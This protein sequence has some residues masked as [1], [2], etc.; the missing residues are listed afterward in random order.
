MNESYKKLKEPEVNK[1]LK[2]KISINDKSTPTKI[3]NKNKEYIRNSSIS[4]LLKFI[5]LYFH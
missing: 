4:P 5:Y 1:C 3:S 2:P